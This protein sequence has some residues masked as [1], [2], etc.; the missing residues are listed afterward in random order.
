MPAEA[1]AYSQQRAV[2]DAVAVLDGLGVCAVERISAGSTA[3]YGGCIALCTTAY[4]GENFLRRRLLG[5]EDPVV[6]ISM[7]GFAGLH[8]GRRH[9]RRR[10]SRLVRVES[11][12]E[13]SGGAR[14]PH[15]VRW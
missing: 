11:E 7:G 13:D 2:D 5:E 9:G 14:Q 4:W 15:R 12:R 10:P 8:V 6:G 1:G 3:P